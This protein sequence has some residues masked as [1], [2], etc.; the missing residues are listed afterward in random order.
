[1]S[2]THP[3]SPKQISKMPKEKLPKNPRLASSSLLQEYAVGLGRSG[4]PHSTGKQGSR[5]GT[6]GR[7][8]PETAH[9]KA[10]QSAAHHDTRQARRKSGSTF[11]ESYNQVS[12]LR[13]DSVLPVIITDSSQ[14]KAGCVW[15][16][17]RKEEGETRGGRVG[18]ERKKTGKTLG[19]TPEAY[20]EPP[21]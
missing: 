15:K 4:S 16:I 13:S 19:Y 9:N 12:A 11:K 17:K 5:K 6:G 18:F 1:M 20:G 2:S 10:C 14:L 7:K 8:K 21:K 3:A